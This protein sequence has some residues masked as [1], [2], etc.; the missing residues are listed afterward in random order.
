[1]AF[2]VLS[3]LKEHWITYVLTAIAAG[4]VA[5]RDRIVTG[6]TSALSSHEIANIAIAL[7]GGVLL[8]IGLAAFLYSRLRNRAS[9]KDYEIY[10]P[11]IG[12]TVYRMKESDPKFDHD[13][14]YCPRCLV[15]DGKVAHLNARHDMG[16]VWECVECKMTVNPRSKRVSLTRRFS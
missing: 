10:H 6:M 16:A 13:I 1:M 3:S 4:L 11:N 15:T 7:F 2:K 12:V 14:W 8:L 5:I 9:I